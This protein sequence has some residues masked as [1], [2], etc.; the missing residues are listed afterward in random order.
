MQLEDAK[1]LV[2]GG[3]RGIGREIA[4]AMARAGAHV[5]AGARDWN[6]LRGREDP[7]IV[8]IELDVTDETSVAERL[9]ELGALDVLVN[10][11]G[12][13]VSGAIEEVGDTELREQYETNLFGPWRLCRAVLPQMRACGSGAI[14]NICSIG[15]ELAYPGLGAYRSSKFALRCLSWTLHFEVAH[16]GIRVLNVEPGA[17]DTDFSTKSVKPGRGVSEASPYAEMRT[18]AESAYRRIAPARI[19]PAAVAAEVVRALR[20]ETGSVDLI[21]GPDAAALAAFR[22]AGMNAYEHALVE[23]FG[24]DWHPSPPRMPD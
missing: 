19:S 12:L 5:W 6:S 4:L 3:S 15:G 9:A 16:F 17:V 11:A 1:C 18:K 24:F 23:T 7:G 21:V 8:P 22:T 10:N 13:S 20:T 2:T 14:V